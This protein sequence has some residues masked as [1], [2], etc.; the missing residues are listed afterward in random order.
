MASSDSRPSARIGSMTLSAYR[1]FRQQEMKLEHEA[2]L[3][4]LRQRALLLV[5]VRPPQGGGDGHDTALMILPTLSKISL[6]WLSLII[7]GGLNAKVSPTARSI[8]SWL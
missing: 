5:H 3:G 2:E 7:S 6:I 8:R 4:E 1:G